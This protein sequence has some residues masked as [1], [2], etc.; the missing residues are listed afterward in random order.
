MVSSSVKIRSGALALLAAGALLCSTGAFAAGDG[1]S[2][3]ARYQRDV[4]AC[5]RGQTAEDHA[6][7]MREAGAALQESRRGDLTNAPR[8]DKQ[9]N[10]Q[11]RCSALTGSDYEACQARMRGEGTVSGSV[12]GGGLLRET[13]T[14]VPA[15]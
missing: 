4:A 9:A 13:V 1:D 3:Q 14:E 2:A 6:T 8:S 5:N 10:A 11:S 15:K 7:C 12:S